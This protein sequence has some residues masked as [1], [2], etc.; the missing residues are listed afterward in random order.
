[1]VLVK[2]IKINIYNINNM[3]EEEKEKYRAEIINDI[4]EFSL[5]EDIKIMN[6]HET[7]DFCEYVKQSFDNN[8]IQRQKFRE[9][10]LIRN[11]IRSKG[12]SYCTVC[13]DT[14]EEIQLILIPN[15]PNENKHLC[16]E[17]FNCQKKIGAK[18]T[19]IKNNISYLI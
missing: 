13:G 9:R 19:D 6:L 4:L 1:M 3:K 14:E 11:K 7:A 15:A 16:I 17:C 18:F 10:L 8:P 12:K 2:Y 5:E